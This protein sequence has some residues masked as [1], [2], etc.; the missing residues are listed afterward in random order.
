M[1]NI[2][3]I[4]QKFLVAVIEFMQ[5]KQEACNQDKLRLAKR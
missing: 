5:N 1:P 4:F 2:N 3:R